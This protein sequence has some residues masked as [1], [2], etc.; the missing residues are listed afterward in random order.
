MITNG[1][2]AEMANNKGERYA[3]HA[4]GNGDFNHHCIGFEKIN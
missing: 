1:T 4:S 3:I 2:Y